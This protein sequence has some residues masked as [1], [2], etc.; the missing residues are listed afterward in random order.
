M[1]VNILRRLFAIPLFI[2]LI[3]IRGVIFIPIDIP[4]WIFTGND[5]EDHMKPLVHKTINWYWGK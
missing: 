3:F 1:V 5:I 4:Y 2:I